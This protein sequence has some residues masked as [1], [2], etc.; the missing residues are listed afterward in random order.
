MLLDHIGDHGRA[1]RVR[2][3]LEKTIKEG[4]AVTSDMGGTS[5][6]EQFTDAVI[7]ALTLA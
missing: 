3:A 4:K 7:A 5:S 1:E 2:R 6:T